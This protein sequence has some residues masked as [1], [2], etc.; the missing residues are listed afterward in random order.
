MHSFISDKLLLE[1]EHPN[2]PFYDI[3]DS[4]AEYRGSSSDS[5]AYG[6][7]QEDFGYEED[8]YDHYDI[9]LKSQRTQRHKPTKLKRRP[10]TKIVLPLL[11]TT[12][13]TYVFPVEVLDLVCSHLSQ[14]TLRFTISLVCKEWSII[15]KRYIQRTGVWESATTDEENRLLSR[16]PCLT[17]L[18]CRLGIS[19]GRA[20]AYDQLLL[21]ESLCESWMRFMTA[22][23]AP[24]PTLDSDQQHIVSAEPRCLLHHI[25][26]LIFRGPLM[27]YKLAIPPILSQLQFL[28]SLELHMSLTRI[29]L[30]EIL[31]NSPSLRELKV[32]GQRF[33]DTQL[34]CGDEEDLI[35]EKPDPIINPL[36]A[37][38]PKKPLVSDPPKTYPD[39][40]KLQVFDVSFVVVKQRIVE[41]LLATC[42]D[43]RVFKLHEINHKIWIPELMVSKILA[44]D[45][46]RLWNHLQNCCPK[47]DWYHIS[48][49][50]NVMNEQMEALTR[51]RQSRILGRFLTTACSKKWNDY[52][53]DL[54]VRTILSHVTVLEV[55]PTLNYQRESYTLQ[56]LLCLMPNLLHLIAG[57]AFEATDV[58]VV[59]GCGRPATLRERFNYHNGSRKRQERMEKQQ[60]RL[61][62]LERF[63]AP[64]QKRLVAISDVWQCR[65][66][67]SMDISFGSMSE[68]FGVFTQ[69]VA[70][71]RLLRNLTSLSIALSELRV[72][73]V[74]E[75]TA[76]ERTPPERWENDLLNLRGLRCLE[77]L[78]ISTGVIEGVVQ[79]TDFEFL[80]KHDPSQ[81]MVMITAKNKD[82]GSDLEEDSLR[83][84]RYR[85]RKDR[86]IWPQLQS[87][88]IRYHKLQIATEF[89][90]V[91][92][93]VEQIRPGVK[94][95][96]QQV[97]KRD[98]RFYTY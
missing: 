8:F 72:G 23:S 57:L 66:L 65:D 81:V 86:T 88:H 71:H 6:S 82:A 76:G 83:N 44:I 70:A 38:L 97:C 92:A 60:Q 85:R 30:F 34:H 41:R 29:A 58:L 19:L 20:F 17:T 47:I 18:E 79:G 24:L 90:D 15:S 37:H 2:D 91:V 69:Y 55:R 75:T 84:N 80:R 95:V 63:Q 45:E 11:R 10:E 28:R 87:F 32:V 53:K 5:D 68:R 89:G 16:M 59:P 61:K 14:A 77:M 22:I 40:Y 67:R 74:I 96:I 46:E 48:L 4:G 49:A 21:R 64:K 94:L 51:M 36:T 25:R 98:M 9:Q 3:Y 54:N 1:D 73:Q 7:S 50:V 43:L 52:L 13:K 93:G 42:P 27:T 35:L 33:H 62:A 31:N 56:Q 26:R 39:R 12:R 78:E